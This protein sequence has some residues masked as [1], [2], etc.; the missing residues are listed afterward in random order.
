[1]R[2]EERQLLDAGFGITAAGILQMDGF[3]IGDAL[4]IESGPALDSLQ[5]ELAQGNWFA[6]P[7]SPHILSGQA[8]ISNDGR[9]LTIDNSAAQLT[10][11]TAINIDS[12]ALQPTHGVLTPLTGELASVSSLNE[13]IVSD[14]VI[15]GGGVVSLT[16]ADFDT[17]SVDAHSLDVT[18]SNDLDLGDVRLTGTLTVTAGGD[19]TDADGATID[20]GGN[21]SFAGANIS[22]GDHA[23]N[24]LNFDSVH[25]NSSGH[26][27]IT[28]ADSMHLAGISTAASATLQ[29]TDDIDVDSDT[30]LHSEGGRITLEAGTEGTLR[31]FGTIDVSDGNDG[32]VAGRAEL[33][34]KYVGIFNDARID[35]SG[36]AGGGIVLVGGDYQGTNPDIRNTDV[37]FLAAEATIMADAIATGDGGT[38]IVWAD[39][40]TRFY[41]TISARGGVEGGDGGFAEVSGKQNLAFHGQVDL[42]AEAGEIGMLLLDP[43]NIV[44]HGGSFDGDDDGDTFTTAFDHPTDTADPTTVGFDD[45]F[46]DE[47]GNA[48]DF[49]IYESDIEGYQ[50][51]FYFTGLK[52]HKRDRHF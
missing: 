8:L 3:D 2:L 43:E 20:V 25:F 24:D 1:M 11:I 41:G 50:L 28:E 31:F 39:N 30:T 15:T 37:T 44:L 27:R 17:L 47:V 40:L 33:L 49:D 10:P 23:T 9:T 6:D 38:V 42:R 46:T 32:M 29:A 36:D 7:A 21:A 19:I 34:G 16:G 14:L 12:Q 5:F 48:A 51:E 45:T 22:L 52:F 26:V 18:D 13:F 35:A 4:A